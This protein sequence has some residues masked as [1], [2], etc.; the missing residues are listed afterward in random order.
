MSHPSPTVND[1]TNPSLSNSKYIVNIYRHF[2]AGFQ[3]ENL[4]FFLF[5]PGQIILKEA[6]SFKGLGRNSLWKIEK[7]ILVQI[8]GC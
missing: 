5:F 8:L 3:R 7:F 4:S 6:G 1:L 2:E